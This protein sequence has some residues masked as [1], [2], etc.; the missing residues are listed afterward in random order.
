MGV[1]GGWRGS[2]KKERGKAVE[3]EDE[4]EDEDGASGEGW[5]G[6]VVKPERWLGGGGGEGGRGVKTHLFL[7]GCELRA[8]Q[9]RRERPGSTAQADQKHQLGVK[10]MSR[11]K[12]RL[13]P[14]SKP[15]LQDSNSAKLQILMGLVRFHMTSFLD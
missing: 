11:F 13:G 3:L 8:E 4:D 9:R 15:S 1:A 12:R 7:D 14:V 2:E 6:C 10:Y 5:C